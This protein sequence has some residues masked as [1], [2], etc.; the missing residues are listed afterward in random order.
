MIT[1][2]KNCIKNYKQDI[3]VKANYRVET[4]NIYYTYKWQNIEVLIQS[5]GLFNS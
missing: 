1:Y 5:F 3:P 4:L 2:E